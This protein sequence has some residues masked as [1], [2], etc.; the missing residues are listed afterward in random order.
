MMTK[1]STAG[2]FLKTRKKWKKFILLC[3]L[4]HKLVYICTG[5]DSEI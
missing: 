3:S 1:A 5:V 4:Y 2:V